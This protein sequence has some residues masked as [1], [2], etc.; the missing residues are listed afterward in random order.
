MVRKMSERKVR[1]LDLEFLNFCEV[2]LD[3]K[4]LILKKVIRWTLR[5]R[6]VLESGG[7]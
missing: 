6:E 3:A 7:L 1:E 5:L 4:I 2:D